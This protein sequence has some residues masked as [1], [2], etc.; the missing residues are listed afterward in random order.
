M[1]SLKSISCAWPRRHVSHNDRFCPCGCPLRSTSTRCLLD[2]PPSRKVTS[3]ACCCFKATRRLDFWSLEY[4]GWP[5]SSSRLNLSLLPRTSSSSDTSYWSVGV[6][7]GIATPLHRLWVV[8]HS[9]VTS[10]P[11]NDLLDRLCVFVCLS[12]FF[13]VCRFR[14]TV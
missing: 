7:R 10:I 6:G 13:L 4:E 5:I 11:P 12:F 1:S 8:G 14:V 9:N 2:P 3:W